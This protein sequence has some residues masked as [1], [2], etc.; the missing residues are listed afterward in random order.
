MSFCL[1][2]WVEWHGTA[3]W[4]HYQWYV[5]YIYTRC[6]RDI[7]ARQYVIYPLSL[8]TAYLPSPRVTAIY[9]DTTNRIC[10]FTMSLYQ[11]QPVTTVVSVSNTDTS[12]FSSLGHVFQHS[13][14][15]LLILHYNTETTR[16]YLF[17]CELQRYRVN[18][19]FFFFR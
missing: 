12:F 9:V 7:T 1:W 3:Y 16:I 17:F 10:F 14:I 8:W 18:I 2:V 11:W 15:S 19:L 13:S 6:A 4:S 5:V